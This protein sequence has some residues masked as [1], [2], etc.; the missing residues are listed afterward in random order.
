MK[1]MEGVPVMP[2]FQNI[3]TRLETFP[4]PTTQGLEP[5]P[6]VALASAGFYYDRSED[7]VRCFWCYGG[8]DI[9][10]LVQE[11]WEHH[12][13]GEYCLNIRIPE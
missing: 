4:N 3:S 11:T 5:V 8:I 2:A 10:C 9:E 1:E 6:S 12:A 7:I 13:R